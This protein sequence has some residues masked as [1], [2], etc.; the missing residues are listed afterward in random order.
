[1]LEQGIA[2]QP[3]FFRPEGPPL[4]LGAFW[5]DVVAANR[6]PPAAGTVGEPE[7]LGATELAAFDAASADAV[8]ALVRRS[9][10]R[11]IW[12]T[13][14]ELLL[15]SGQKLGLALVTLVRKKALPS[16]RTIERTTNELVTG[17]SQQ[18]CKST[19]TLLNE[20]QIGHLH[21]VGGSVATFEPVRR[22]ERD[23]ALPRAP[24][25]PPHADAQQRSA[26][27]PAHRASAP[28]SATLARPACAASASSRRPSC[29]PTT[30]PAPRCSRPRATTR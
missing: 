13:K 5:Q 28:S 7:G 22:A 18:V 2:L 30:A 6:A 19:A 16:A 23:R 1:M 9:T 17:S 3:F 12:R 15:P 25:E 20:F 14:A 29:S 27:L 21:L 8:R 4:Q 10:A 11:R 26:P 24:G